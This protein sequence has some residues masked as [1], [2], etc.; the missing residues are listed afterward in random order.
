MMSEIPQAR[1]ISLN[2]LL[3]EFEADAKQRN[4]AKKS[5]SPLGAVSGLKRL[6]QELGG[7]PAIGLHVLHGSPGS[8][9]T[10]FGLQWATNCNCPCLYVT[11]EMTPI[12]LLR[13]LASRIT[14]TYLGRFKTGELSPD[15]ATKFAR[16][17]V[18]MTPLLS[19]I[20]ATSSP[21]DPSFIHEC[22]SV[23]RP[24]APDNPN[25]LVVVDSVHSWVRGFSSTVPEYDALNTG[26][27]SLRKLSQTL[28]CP[29][30]CIAERNRASMPSGG[31]NASAGTRG[32]EYGSES[33]IGLDAEE[34]E[35]A[36]RERMVKLT[37]SKN[38]HGSQGKEIKLFFKG[39]T[40]SFR[41][42]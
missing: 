19:L 16:K 20:D 33:V 30:L 11:C 42:E 13:R 17:A 23:V 35:N 15:E 29:V 27:D 41:E 2:S 36:S 28:N 10:A 3:C 34:K 38:R 1:L 6:D 7:A 4:D 39:A 37:L 21:A 24:L 26:L 12:E 8:G 22:S 31:Q 5:G 9:K 25:F 14:G 40:Q 32:F 18:E